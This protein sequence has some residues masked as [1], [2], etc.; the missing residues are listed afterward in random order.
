MDSNEVLIPQSNLSIEVKDCDDA[1]DPWNQ[2]DLGIKGTQ[3]LDDNTLFVKTHI[4][5]LCGGEGIS[6]ASY[7]LEDTELELSYSTKRGDQITR[8]VCAKELDYTI[9]NLPQKEYS[10]SLKKNE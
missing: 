6:K 10:V 2:T 1:I 8:C 5:M 7:S 9:S 3:W 4:S